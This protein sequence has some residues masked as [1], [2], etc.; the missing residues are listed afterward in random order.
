MRI[1]ELKKELNRVVE[2]HSAIAIRLTGSDNPQTIKAFEYNS[3]IVETLVA[4]LE[5]MDGDKLILDLL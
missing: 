2:K 4:V 5:Y 1:N 3:H